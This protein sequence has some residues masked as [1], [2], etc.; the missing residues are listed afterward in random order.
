MAVSQIYIWFNIG[1][2]AIRPYIP[3]K[4]GYLVCGTHLPFLNLFLNHD[5]GFTVYFLGLPD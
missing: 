3:I 2:I 5:F 1:R 4:N